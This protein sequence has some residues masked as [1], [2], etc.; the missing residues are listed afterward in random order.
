MYSGNQH[1]VVKEFSSN[2]K[3]KRFILI[4]DNPHLGIECVKGDQ[5]GNVGVDG[6]VHRRSELRSASSPASMLGTCP[7]HSLFL[8]S[9]SL[10]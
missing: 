5:E 2:Q 6:T 10:C 7:L 9:V 1:N 4:L 3:K 8:I